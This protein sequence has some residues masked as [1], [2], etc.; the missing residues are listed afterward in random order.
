MRNNILETSK[1]T[2]GSFLAE[3]ILEH[4]GTIQKAAEKIGL[5]PYIISKHVRMKIRPAYTS[6]MLYSK[7]LMKRSG[8]LAFMIDMDWKS[9]NNG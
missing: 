4:D 8:D 3:Y 6:I 2:F 5:H 7:Y 9:A 1:G